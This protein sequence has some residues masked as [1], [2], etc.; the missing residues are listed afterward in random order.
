MDFLFF[1]VDN[2]PP[3]NP[4]VFDPYKQDCAG[5]ALRT[6]NFGQDAFLP[7]RGI[8]IMH[9]L[10]HDCRIENGISE[11]R[12]ELTLSDSRDWFRNTD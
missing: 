8:S 5:A 6:D 11:N 3:S 2:R 10:M 9:I 12:I 4:L 1:F 7:D